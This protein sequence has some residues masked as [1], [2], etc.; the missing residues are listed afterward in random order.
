MDFN[1]GRTYVAD[2]FTEH[3]DA[4][5]LFAVSYEV[6]DYTEFYA[7]NALLGG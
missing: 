6:N 5:R 2:N 1:S 7:T 3:V 4:E